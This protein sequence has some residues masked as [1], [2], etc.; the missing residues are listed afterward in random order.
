MVN[1]GALQPEFRGLRADASEKPPW[2]LFFGA[3][4]DNPSLYSVYYGFED[5]G[6]VQ[7]IAA[8]EDKNIVGAHKA[9]AA[10]KWI[11]RSI[12]RRPDGDGSKRVQRWIY[13]DG[14]YLPIG[15]QIDHATTYDP[16]ERPWYK[17]AAVNRPQLTPPYMFF[18]LGQPGITSY[19]RIKS[20]KG[21]FAVD[22]TLTELRRFVAKFNISENGGVVLFDK[23][24]RILTMSPQF[25]EHAPLADMQGMPLRAVRAAH[26]MS[27]QPHRKGLQ[28]VEQDGGTLLVQLLDWE[29]GGS[30]L[31]IAVVAPKSDFISHV[32]TMQIL[33]L[34]LLGLILFLPAAWIFSNRMS[35][36]LSDLIA[37]SERVRRLDFSGGPL[38][39]TRIIEFDHLRHF[40]LLMKQDLS[41]QTDA[42]TTAETKLN[43]LVELGIAMSSE[44]NSNKLVEMV[45][46][47]AKELASADGGSLYTISGDKKL[48]FQIV[49]NT[50]LGITLGGTSSDPVTLP[51][52]PLFDEN[53]GANHNNV[54]SHT[55]HEG[56]TVNIEDAYDPTDFDF[57]GTRA[58]DE[59]NGY[60]SQSFMT[61]PLRPRGG[62]CIGALQLVNALDPET[63]E[64]VP[65][66]SEIQAFV[67]ALA[68]QAATALHNR[69]LID[70]QER[71]MDALIRLIAGAIDIKSPYTG[72]HCKRVPE[73]AIMLAEDASECDAGPFADFS[74]DTDEEW[75]EFRI[76]AWLHDCGKVVT[77]EY[78]VD[79]ATKLETIYNRINE[80]RMR[81]EVLLRDADIERLEATAGGAEVETAEKTFEARKT[82]LIDDFA[83]IAECNIG[84]EF[85]APERLERLKSIA[86]NVWLRHF[87][88]RLSLSRVE[89]L[90]YGDA[91]T[92][93]PVEEKLLDDKPH[94]V[95]ERHRAVHQMYEDFEFKMD[96]PEHLYNLGELHNLSIS[97][98]T[99]TDEERFKI[100]EHIMQ[101]VVMLEHLPL[102]KHLRRVPEYAGTHHEALTG[103]GYPRKLGGEELSIPA[104]IMAI[105]DIFEA[106]TACDR[107]YKD[108]KKLSEAVNILNF[109]K[110]DGHIDPDLFDLFLTSGTYRRYAER[111]LDPDQ[112]DEVDIEPYLGREESADE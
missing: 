40:F 42:L 32:T 16:C 41:K 9:P 35:R 106:L 33:W 103:D 87:D 64:T 14:N 31:R 7:L 57:S 105:A 52:A 13:L 72:G 82:E 29:A 110:K 63:G 20:G 100:N 2:S 60:R 15:S 62:E 3:L 8:R 91:E 19:R 97:R 27:M 76:G 30:K 75:W 71:L 86:E 24:N 44:S 99:L 37:D 89:R 70:A 66:S 28:F 49:R 88:D 96:I 55:V 93:L 48:H 104:R 17:I 1:L 18:S 80:I 61:V 112:I 78:A 98:G 39:D 21:V 69:D 92:I 36:N 81:F 102:P 10:T 101:T 77:P 51:P 90:R 11:V 34:P 85:M 25:G 73:L 47:G 23:Q 109:F 74:F 68:A 26:D 38:R 12:N 22:I 83:F 108:A 56:R 4:Q 84:G 107:P 46:T 5:G 45:L 111:Y 65:F 79:K 59:R 54:V 6:F 95:I 67:E 50:S 58:F 53:G 94:H 43:R